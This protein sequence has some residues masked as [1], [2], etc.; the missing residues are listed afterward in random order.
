MRILKARANVAL[1]T[2]LVVIVAASRPLLTYPKAIH[3]LAAPDGTRIEVLITHEV[4]WLE[5]LTLGLAHRAYEGYGLSVRLSDA[6]DR[7]EVIEIL[8]PYLGKEA[9]VKPDT[10]ELENERLV[11]TSDGARTIIDVKTGQELKEE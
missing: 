5:C 11:L 4:G 1:A 10:V 9:D 3:R 8:P 7:S 2:G 6:A